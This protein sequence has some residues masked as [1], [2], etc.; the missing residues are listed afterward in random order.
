MKTLLLGTL[1]GLN[2]LGKS[3]AKQEVHLEFSDLGSEAAS[4]CCGSHHTCALRGGEL[5][6]G[7][8]DFTNSGDVDGLS[9]C[10][11]REYVQQTDAPDDERFVQVSC[12]GTFTCGLTF[13]EQ[14]R[15]WGG[16]GGGLRGRFVQVSSGID[17]A[18]A[19][20]LLGHV[21][22]IGRNSRGESSPPDPE[23]TLGDG[24]RFVQVSAGKAHSCALSNKGAIVCWGSNEK[25]QCNTPARPG[26][27]ESGQDAHED[28]VIFGVAYKQVVASLGKHTCALEVKT[29]F[30][31]CWGQGDRSGASKAPPDVSF[32]SLA[33]GRKFTCGIRA[34]DGGIQCWGRIANTPTSGGPFL[35]LSAGED[36]A[37]ASTASGELKCWGKGTYSKTAT[38]DK[39]IV[40]P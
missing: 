33:A 2:S 32:V 6:S 35:Q 8:P 14:V 20:S 11:G 17:H 34:E 25:G 37:C 15:C 10:W 23:T 26:E 13:D 1:F 22:C 39:L 9:L 3:A 18:C 28:N 27:R 16:I 19:V 29:G 4:F 12:G 24:E 21:S 7:T 40:L 5:V 31:R 38:P 36:H 30:A